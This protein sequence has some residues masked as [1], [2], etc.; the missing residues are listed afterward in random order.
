MK[1]FISSLPEFLPLPRCLSGETGNK[2]ERILGHSALVGAQT[3]VGVGVTV[4]LGGAQPVGTPEHG[5]EGRQLVSPPHLYPRTVLCSCNDTP[6]K[7][8]ET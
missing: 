4:R 6:R 5:T 2:R 1:K 3:I 7:G 8:G